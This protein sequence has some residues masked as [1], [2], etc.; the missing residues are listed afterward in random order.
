MVYDMVLRAVFLVVTFT[1]LF[2]N[3]DPTGILHVQVKGAGWFGKEDTQREMQ[4]HGAKNQFTC[5][6]GTRKNNYSRSR[7]RGISGK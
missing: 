5:V 6:V 7:R 4:G 2:V 1:I 3:A